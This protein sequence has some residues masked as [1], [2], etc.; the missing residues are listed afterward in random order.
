MA[1]FAKIVNSEVV[2]IVC[3]DN[4]VLQGKDYPNADDIGTKYLNSHG[5]DG[6]WIQTSYSSSFRKNTASIGSIWDSEMDCFYNKERPHSECIW[7]EDLMRWTS[8]Q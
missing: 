4:E 6:E 8:P 1:H 2:D 7:N 3:I 5:F